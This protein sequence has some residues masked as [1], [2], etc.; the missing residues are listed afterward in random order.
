MRWNNN[1]LAVPYPT[2]GPKL[3]LGV[4]WFALIVIAIFASPV[5]VA[6]VA[7]GVAGLAG[8][9]TGHAWYPQYSSMKWWTA[10]AAIVTALGGALG[11]MGLLIS[12]G[13]G[14][15]VLLAHL[16]LEPPR[17]RSTAEQLDVLFRSALPVGIAAGSLAALAAHDANAA[18]LLVA[19]VSAYEAGDFLVGTGSSNAIEGPLSGLV[20][21]A[22]VGF[23]AR[24]LAPAPFTTTSVVLFA[25]LAAVCC[26]LGQILAAAILPRGSAWA[27]AL[28]RLD[29]YLL[30]A[31]LWLLLLAG[32]SSSSTL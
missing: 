23:V 11:A 1:R 6:A 26:P 25:A 9:Q 27:P 16:A 31:P 28:R 24:V 18:L 19:F 13:M 10:M 3:T 22:V 14:A 5:L 30:A 21:L 32:V 12:T 15:I 7:A 20:A 4:V 2:D 8:L 17:T 29:S